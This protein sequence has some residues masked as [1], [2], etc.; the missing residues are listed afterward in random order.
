MTLNDKIRKPDETFEEA[1]ATMIGIHS[2]L[3]TLDVQNI[4]DEYCRYFTGFYK[5]RGFSKNTLNRIF[6]HFRKVKNKGKITF[7]TFFS[8]LNKI[9]RRKEISFT[10]KFMHTLYPDDY[11]IWDSQVCS[12]LKD[13]GDPLL[14]NSDESI[15]KRYEA[16]NKEIHDF[17]NSD[18]GRR[19]IEKFDETFPHYKDKIK[20]IKKI[21][22]ALWGLGKSPNKNALI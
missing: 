14:D 8:E 15:I 4:D 10:S 3:K 17:A 1:L 12:L 7:G 19:L 20:S 16:F 22:F 11:A 9:T 6:E 18:S 5:L 2:Y 21:D 13:S